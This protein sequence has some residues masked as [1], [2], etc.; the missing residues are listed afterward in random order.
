M[1]TL[2]ISDAGHRF[3]VQVREDVDLPAPSTS[4]IPTHM[5]FLHFWRLQ[6]SSRDIPYTWSIAEPQG[7]RIVR[8][9]LRKHTI[10]ELQKLAIHCFFDHGDKLRANPHHL[11]IFA[12]LVE[13]MKGELRDRA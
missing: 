12:S 13:T 4:G 10:E 11:A 7:I 8:S 9:L 6:C 2:T 1:T 3:Q 5:Q